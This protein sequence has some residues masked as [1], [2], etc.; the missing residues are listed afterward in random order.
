M[1]TIQRPEFGALVG[2]V[3]V[4]AFFVVF[5][6]DQGFTTLAGT[7]GWLNTAAELGIIA[8][9]AG[10]LLI[11]GEF[12]LSV[13]ST[14]AGAS[15]ITAIGA[16][17][18]DWP[19]GV[20]IALALVFGLAVGWV[21]GTL[22]RHTRLPS[23][24]VTLAVFLALAGAELGL[25]AQHHR[26]DP[27][28]HPRQRAAAARLRGLLEDLGQHRHRVVGRRRGDRDLGPDAHAPSATGSW[29]PAGTSPRAGRPA[30]A[31]SASRRSCSW[32]RRSLQ[33]WWA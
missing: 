7:A 1:S 5:A 2:T 12:Y 28:D 24:I 25:R 10:L 6:S 4:Y 19:L 26:H 23:F 3:L 15:V 30:S 31:S 20:A 32:R 29:P 8:V 17:H 16:A 21:N 9:P 27:A 33:R 11:A 14:I 22:V 18:Y 13:G